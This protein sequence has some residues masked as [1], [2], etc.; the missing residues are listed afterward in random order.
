MKLV[1]DAMLGRLATWLRVLGLDTVFSASMTASQFLTWVGRGRRGL[2]RRTTL[3]GLPEIIFVESDHHQDQL[4]QVVGELGLKPPWEGLFTRC[5]RCNQELTEVERSE[6]LG[7]VPEYVYQTQDLF[8]QC[9]LCGR[10]YWSGTH[11]DRMLAWLDSIGLEQGSPG[12]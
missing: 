8:R 1:A 11:P 6:V 10:I 3:R 9:P 2:T 7:R 5:G 4:I 12:R